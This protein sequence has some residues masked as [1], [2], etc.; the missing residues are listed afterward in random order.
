MFKSKQACFLQPYV[1][2]LMVTEQALGFLSFAN[3]PFRC[4][5]NNALTSAERLLPR[6]AFDIFSRV[7]CVTVF[8]NR[9]LPSPENLKDNFCLCCSDIICLERACLIFSRDSSECLLPKK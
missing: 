1:L 7:T 9:G 2:P 3:L 8:P 6:L 4:F 5:D